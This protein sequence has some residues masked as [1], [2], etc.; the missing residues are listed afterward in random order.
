MPYYTQPDRILTLIEALNNQTV[1]Q[2]K[3]L[4]GLLPAG[5]LPTRKAELVDYVYQRMQGKSL[6]QLWE[7]CA[8]LQ[9]AVIAEVVHGTDERYHKK[10]FISK[11][12]QEPS[13]GTGERY[14]YRYKPSILGLFF[15]SYT[16]PQDLKSQFKAFVPPPEPTRIQSVD[17]LP[18]ALSGTEKSYDDKTRSRQTRALAIP[19]HVRETESVARRDV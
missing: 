4:A 14:S 17:L 6:K 11:Y 18:A 3:A 15:S 7:Q 5:T 1:D 16:M 8:P 10:R 9:K 12:G 2:L 13:W 19:L